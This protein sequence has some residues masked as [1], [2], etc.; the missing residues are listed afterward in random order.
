MDRIPAHPELVRLMEDGVA[1]GVF[2]G[3][4]LA[5]TVGGRTVH[6]SFHG[7][8]S[9]EPPGD[10][11]DAVTCF[12]LASLTKVLAA[13][14]LALLAIQR[15]CLELDAPVG[16]YLE[17]YAGQGREAVTVRMLLEHSS[18]LPAW[19]PYHEAVREA[20]GGARL[21][22]AAGRDLVRRLTAA[23]A[24][25]APPGSRTLY[26]DLGFILLA[27]ILERATGQSLDRLFAEQ[28]AGPLGLAALFFVEL[29][30]PAR[31]AEARRARPFA[32]TER[33]PWRGRVLV[34]EVHDDITYAMGGVSGQAGLFGTLEDVS[35]LAEAW[36][37]C[38]RS[39]G[40]CFD[41]ALVRQFWTRSAV[42]GSTRCVGFD[43]PSPAGSQAGSGFGPRTVGH[44]GFTGTSLWIDPERELSVVL[45]TNRVHPTRQNDAIRRFRP[46]LHDRV[47]AL[48]R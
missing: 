8:C 5:V 1:G 19:R 25:E 21:A 46:A 27:W 40:G 23:E 47:A 36:L 39:D 28:L 22:T 26:S 14:P 12:D 15:G 32:A 2:P 41:R 24:P 16:R 10:R 20:E 6:R 33:C 31:A 11:V 38:R 4:A 34:G 37:R 13:A 30:P 7:R 18:G 43:T 9:L 35:A 48:W 42:P 17:G 45:L 3:G 29:A 44:L